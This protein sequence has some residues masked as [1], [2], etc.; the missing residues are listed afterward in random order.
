M[1]LS[2]ERRLRLG[3]VIVCAATFIVVLDAAIMNVALPSIQ[4]SLDM[5]ESNLQWVVN[6]YTLILG[7]FLL[8]GGR[9]ADLFGRRRVFMI[10]L[11]IFGLASA[12]GGLAQTSLWLIIARGFEGFGSA[13][14]APA[15][16]AILYTMFEEEGARHRAVGIYGAMGSGGA[17]SGALLGGIIVQW[18]GWEWC[19]FVN[20]P[21]AAVA[22]ALCPSLVPMGKPAG[23][24]PRLDVAGAFTLTAALLLLVYAVVEVNRAG[25]GSAEILGCLGGAA[26]LFAA[27][28]A[29]ETRSTSPL[30]PFG[31]FRVRSVRGA[32]VVAA[33]MTAAMFAQFY[34]TTLYMQQVLGY[35]AIVTGVAFTP[36]SVTTACGSIL[37]SRVLRR[38]SVQKVLATVMTTLAIGLALLIRISPDGTYWEILGPLLLVAVSF[39]ISLV[40]LTLAA[41][42]GLDPADSGIGSGLLNTSR[43]VGGAIGLAV[44]SSVAASK[45]HALLAEGHAATDALN[46]GFRWAYAIGAGIAFAGAVAAFVMLRG[47]LAA[48]AAESSAGEFAG[49]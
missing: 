29:V 6:A 7:G 9:C 16:L 37:I 14:I 38:L 25:W 27:F 17:A 35:S 18:L 5:T 24:R 4:R 2:D 36:L 34:F 40:A 26:A 41:L 13:L 3:F 30:I 8:L 44:M 19:L 49:E 10:G 39:G 47:N 12:A 23:K 31:I 32:N 21:I 45:T 48:N 42:A 11:A 15:A 46:G 1:R 20:V 33:C 43:R 22:L 28:I